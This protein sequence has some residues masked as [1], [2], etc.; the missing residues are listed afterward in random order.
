TVDAM[1]FGIKDESSIRPFL[2]LLYGSVKQKSAS[3]VL[4]AEGLDPVAEHVR[5]VSDA[6]ISLN[7]E[8]VLGQSVRAFTILGRYTC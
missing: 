2:Q 8:S 6:I 4:I 1:F 3:M 7:F 5:F